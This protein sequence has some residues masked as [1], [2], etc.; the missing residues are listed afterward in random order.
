M[1]FLHRSNLTEHL[2]AHLS[3]TIQS[4]PLESFFDQ[5]MFLIQSTGMERLLNQHLSEQFGCWGHYHFAFPANFFN[6]LCQ[7]LDVT[8]AASFFERPV[9]TWLIDNFLRTCDDPAF[10][11]L[12]AY[13]HNGNVA[14]KRFQLAQQLAQIF[15]QYQIMR[16]DMLDAWQQGH[17]FY[18][19]EHELW[20][21]I[22][23]QNITRQIGVQHRGTVWLTLIEHLSK[24]TPGQLTFRLPQ[25]L[26]VFGI[27]SLPPLFLQC[28]KA[29]SHHCDIHLYLLE[30]SQVYWADLPNKKLSTEL[31]DVEAHPLLATL[32]QQG[33]EFQ[34]LLLE[35]VEFDMDFESFN[36]YPDDSNLHRLQNDILNNTPTEHVLANDGSISIHSCHSRFREVEVI[37][38]LI[39]DELE[40]DSSLNLRDII[41]MAPDIQLYEPYIHAVFSDI[42]HSIADRNLRLT[43]ACLDTFLQFLHLCRSRF[44]WREVMDLLEQPEVYPQFGLTESDLDLINFWINATYTRWAAS[45]AHK[46]ELGL[47]ALDENTWQHT[48]N[49]LLMGYASTDTDQF[50]ENILPYPAIEGLS[51]QALGGLNDF[52][53]MLFNCRQTLKQ[54]Q[55]LT[56]WYPLLLQMADTLL[57][58]Q[59]TPA[60]QQLNELLL[61][62]LEFSAVHD[63][64]VSLA[65]I[66]HWLETTVSEQKTSQGFLRGQLTFCSMLPMRA[67]PF[68]VI[69]L[70]GMND[71]EFPT[72][73]R[74]PVFNLLTRNYRIG[75]RSRRHDD[76]YQFLETL[77]S[78]RKKLI[79]SYIGQSLQHNDEIPPSI[80]ISELLDILSSHYGLSD[81]VTRHPLQAFSHR[82]FDD[83]Q[84]S[85]FSFNAH[86]CETARQL[87]Q[88]EIN[89]SPWWQGN[90]TANLS[91]IIELADLFAFFRHPQKYFF[92][93]QLDLRFSEITQS[94]DEREV[95]NPDGL[96]VY[97]IKQKWLDCLLQ[98]QPYSLQKLQAQGCWPQGNSGKILFDQ[99]E[100]DIQAF[101]N[102]I[103]KI[104][105]GLP[106]PSINIDI[107]IG[108]YQIIGKLGHRYQQGQLLYRFSKM[109][110]KDFM[111]AWL[112]HLI[113]NQI[114]PQ[115]TILACEDRSLCFNAGENPTILMK[116][117]TIYI[118]GQSRPDVFFTEAAFAYLQQSLKP[119]NSVPPL[120]HCLNEAEKHLAY[121]AEIR[122]LYPDKA[123]LAS[124]LTPQFAQLCDDLLIPA[125]KNCDVL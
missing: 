110:G 16:P 28:L 102:K 65:V 53:S 37:K 89:Q 80:I 118:Q 82:Y 117:L 122:Q 34:Q 119:Q 47:P 30:P 68:K 63:Q 74:A 91:P 33:R 23:W 66:I 96:D 1:L 79:I 120:Q 57:A 112:Q 78:V 58:D 7:C 88:P 27:H 71:G 90:I 83:S 106:Q 107:S 99:M 85:L 111:L 98:N 60:R 36:E 14:L 46:K 39:L 18:P 97:H 24:T 92:Q 87:Q 94:V 70:I 31:P 21:K 22:L 116:L 38:N 73:D 72:I 10:T 55:T 3:T 2:L 125:W 44:G 12:L 17:S 84:P 48:L 25:R 69:V 4:Q 5:E 62:L 13:L 43:N 124:V 101:A 86:H 100:P 8:P 42:Q 11:P 105:P 20:Q 32:G 103:R 64:S 113:A 81:L 50:I 77:L 115:S 93:R 52:I 40:H 109:K 29:L 15:D 75:D 49:R 41:V 51:A 9:L 104:T 54:E 114:S 45:S 121:D 123:A 26:S 61:Q 95:F 59:H 67:I 19:D 6:S 108:D 76:R 56:S 35:Q